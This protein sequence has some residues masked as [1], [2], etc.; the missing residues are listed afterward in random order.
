MKLLSNGMVFLLLFLTPTTFAQSGNSNQI[1]PELI[2]KN[3]V[4]IEG[5]AG[6]DGAVYNFSNVA[7]GMDAN[8]KIIRRSGPSVVLT[9][10]DVSDLG[11]TKAFQPDGY[12]R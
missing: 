6:Q 2:F 12:C 4:L 8:V 3:P 9:N 10:I 11:W 1:I 7:A 5:T